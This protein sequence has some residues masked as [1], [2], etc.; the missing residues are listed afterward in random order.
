M[1]E[2]I[3]EQLANEFCSLV[4]REIKIRRWPNHLDV[5]FPGLHQ[6]FVKALENNTHSL[7]PIDPKD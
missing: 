6:A 4:E 2:K 5:Y 1:P 7:D 3:F